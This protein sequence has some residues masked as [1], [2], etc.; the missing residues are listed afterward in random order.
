MATATQLVNQDG[1][2]QLHAVKIIGWGMQG[3]QA[4]WLI[5]NSWGSSW[6]EQG[7]ARI[8]AG[9]AT[10]KQTVFLQEWTFAGT[11]ASSKLG[12][13]ESAS[14]DPTALQEAEEEDEEV[15]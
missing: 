8:A 11:P 12:L 13:P 10:K 1:Q 9:D 15:M 3:K 5:E 14:E 6:G 7:F 2:R 4:Y